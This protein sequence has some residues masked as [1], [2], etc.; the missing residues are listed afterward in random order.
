MG[1]IHSNA[2]G[3]IEQKIRDNADNPLRRH[4]LENARDFKRSWIELGRSLYSVW[5]DKLYKEWGYQDFDNYTAKEI[6]IRKQTAMKLLR[7]YFFLEKEE[8]GYL[9]ESISET[10]KAVN[11]PSYESVD[12]LRLA[13]EKKDLDAEDYANL[14]EAVFQK[15]K[16]SRE[17]KKDL[18]SLIR[19]R[20]ELEP[21]EAWEQKRQRSIKRFIGTLKSLKEEIKSSKMLPASLVQ[22]ADAFIR[23][24]ESELQ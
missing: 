11:V 23:K 2:L 20:Q 24:L 17:V 1:N 4:V 14:K 15:G 18:T 12:L 8:P 19:Q 6:G 22:D 7:S 16:D 10:A 21:E 13:K 9:K 5:K 3:N